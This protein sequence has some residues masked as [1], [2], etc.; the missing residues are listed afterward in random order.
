MYPLHLACPALRRELPALTAAEVGSAQ[1]SA[2]SLASLSLSPDERLLAVA[3]A[4][5]DAVSLFTVHSLVEAGTPAQ[6]CASWQLPAGHR[7]L[8]VRSGSRIC[9]E[10]A[11]LH[12]HSPFVT[13]SKGI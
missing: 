4:A 12:A 13:A 11:C 7:A 3:P 2:D 1:I 9:C 10:S 5:G 6:P 8:Q